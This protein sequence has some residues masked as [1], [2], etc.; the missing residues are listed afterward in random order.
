VN[1]VSYA[2]LERFLT[3]PED[4]IPILQLPKIVVDHLQVKTDI[5]L[6]SAA[7][8]RKNLEHHPDLT[9][10]DYYKLSQVG[11][12]VDLVVQDGA[13]SVVLIRKEYV[14]YWV[15]VKATKTKESLFLTSFRRSHEQDIQRLLRKG[16]I[17]Y[18]KEWTDG[19]ASQ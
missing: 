4:A 17:I 10:D 14:I 15:A 9:L 19:G 16:K 1:S 12:T 8:A 5:V 18:Q 6:F 7:S 13:T 11:T 3:N 2:F